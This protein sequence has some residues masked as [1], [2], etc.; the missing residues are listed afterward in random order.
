MYSIR[1]DDEAESLSNEVLV[2]T[3]NE[4]GHYATKQSIEK[5]LGYAVSSLISVKNALIVLQIIAVAL[6]VTATIMYYSWI[7]IG[8]DVSE[9]QISIFRFQSAREKRM[10]MIAAQIM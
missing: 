10:H 4:Q 1:S 8:S 9:T 3:F 7:L 6:I 5:T 2:K